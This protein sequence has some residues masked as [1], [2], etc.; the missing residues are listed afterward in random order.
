[1]HQFIKKTLL[2]FLFG[3]PA[4]L[5]VLIF[6]GEFM[7]NSF[8]KNLNYS[9]GAYGHM[10]TRIR[11]VKQVKN[12]DILFVG[13]SHAYRGF[14]TRI[15]QQYNYKSFNLGS[16]AQTPVQTKFLL[17]KYLGKL[18]P[19]ILIY[20][21]CAGAFTNDGIESSMDM[22]ANGKVDG[23]LLQ[24]A[25]D[26]NNI[27]VYNSLLYG[28][29]R[30]L[31]NRDRN[32]KENIIIN[33]DTYIPGGFVEHKMMYNADTISGAV[34]EKTLWLPKQYQ[35]T[36]FEKTVSLINQKGIKLILVQAPVV[37]QEYEKYADK[38]KIDNYF[39]S[40]ATYYNFNNCLNLSDSL[41]FYDNNHLNPTGVTIFNKALF[42]SIL[43]K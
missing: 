15:A 4:Y 22:I 37:K 3:V 14:D 23:S 20:E 9:L 31:F 12:I 34:R 33:S 11:E 36:A 21:V 43:K 2:F 32:F 17:Q 18:N 13:S 29:Y 35:L 40:K 16:S 19:K 38:N 42:D 5:V 10:Y 1:M 28:Y 8:K 25:F 27:K 6:W 7:P 26:L 24:M 41:D 39:A 30:Q